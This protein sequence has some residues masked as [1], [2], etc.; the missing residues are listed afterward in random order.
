MHGYRLKILFFAALMLEGVSALS[1]AW[2]LDPRSGVKRDS[3]GNEGNAVADD[4]I[5]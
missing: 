5:K 2:T 4:N 3:T 1:F